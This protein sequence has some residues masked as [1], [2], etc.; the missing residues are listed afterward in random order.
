MSDEP[1]NLVLVYLRRMDAK[2]DKVIDTQQEHGHRLS[3]VESQ[4]AG[5]R[6]DQ[7]SDA[8]AVAHLQAQMDR[9]RDELD[10]VKRRLD[11]VE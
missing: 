1:E 6:R 11:I 4:L 2:I 10:R 7:G 3:R 9:L 5:L 8:E